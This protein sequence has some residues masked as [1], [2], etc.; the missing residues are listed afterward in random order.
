MYDVS[1]NIAYDIWDEIAVTKTNAG[2][3]KFNCSS[4]EQ[5]FAVRDIQRGFDFIA[6]N[7]YNNAKL[8]YGKEFLR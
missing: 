4:F 5:S 6:K 3:F 1:S 2:L 8:K 7:F